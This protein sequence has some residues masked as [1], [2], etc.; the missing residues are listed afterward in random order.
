[1]KNL[2]SKAAIGVLRGTA[3]V[4]CTICGCNRKRK[5]EAFVYENSEEGKKS[6]QEKYR[7]KAN[8]TYTCRICKS[9]AK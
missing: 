2:N 9:I 6:A 7:T 4:S 5:I 1:M 8:K 3:T